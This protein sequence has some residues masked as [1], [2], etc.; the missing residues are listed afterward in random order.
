MKTKP[1]DPKAYTGFFQRPSKKHCNGSKHSEEILKAMI[2]W[3]TTG[4]KVVH[5]QVLISN[6]I[7]KETAQEA[8]KG[9]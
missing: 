1:D 3:M 4:V 5:L 9:M 7:W 2:L 8:R 6:T